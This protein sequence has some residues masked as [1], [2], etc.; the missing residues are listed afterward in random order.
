MG[1]NYNRA[2]DPQKRVPKCPIEKERMILE[3]LKHFKM[4]DKSVEL[5]EREVVESER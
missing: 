2:E 3:A 1:K 5:I 4:V